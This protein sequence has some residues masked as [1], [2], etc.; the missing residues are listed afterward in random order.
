MTDKITKITVAMVAIAI[1]IVSIIN[2]LFKISHP[3]LS[4]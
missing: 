2:N 1:K 4:L 3:I